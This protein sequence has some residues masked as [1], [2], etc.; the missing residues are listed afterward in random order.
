MCA[1]PIDEID[2]ALAHAVATKSQTRDSNKESISHFI[3]EL[4]DARLELE[5][6]R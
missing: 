3:D 2:E 1:N 6:N 4:L 5:Q